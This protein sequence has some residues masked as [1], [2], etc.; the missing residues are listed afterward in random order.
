MEILH[1]E[2]KRKF[3]VEVE[4]YEAHVDYRLADGGLDIR[5]TIVPQEIGGRGIAGLLVKAA[6]DYALSHELK[7]V[8]TCSYAVKWLEKHPEYKGVCGSD[9]AG[10]G[11]CA[12]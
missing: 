9:Y 12:L 6:Y 3:Y 1:N 5:H 10:E 8:A 4:G 7:A 2:E 11:S